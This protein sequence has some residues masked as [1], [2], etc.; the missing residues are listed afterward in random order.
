[1]TSE[2]RGD[3][4]TDNEGQPPQR[5]RKP[6]IIRIFRAFKRQINSQKR[7]GQKGETPHQFNERMLRRWTRN[8]GLFTF[9]LVLVGI[10]TACIFKRQ[11]EVMRNTDETLAETLKATR[12]EERASV[13]IQPTKSDIDPV[14]GD[15]VW[16]ALIGNAGKT[17]TVDLT[18]SVGCTTDEKDVFSKRVLSVATIWSTTR[19]APA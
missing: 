13:F 10:A 9:A 7:R 15:L 8:V 11:L 14:D 12:F 18:Y 3:T 6:I 2:P 16:L 1:M 5:P 4:K 17:P 19:S